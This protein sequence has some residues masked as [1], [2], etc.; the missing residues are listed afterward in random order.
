MMSPAMDNQVA[1]LLEVLDADIRHLEDTLTRLDRLRCLLVKREDSALEGLLEEIRGQSQTCQT[2]EQRRQGLRRELAAALGCSC[3]ELTLS[4]LR[5]VLA[6][7][8]GSETQRRWGMALA[9]RQSRLRTLTAQLTR[10]HTLTVLLIRDCTRFNR[11]LLRLFFESGGRGG[12]M[13]RPNGTAQHQTSVS[14]MSMQL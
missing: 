10:E 9:Q 7:P 5:Q 6:A 13:Y 2:N 12:T 11:S 14:L 8:A 3:G 4:K 1:E